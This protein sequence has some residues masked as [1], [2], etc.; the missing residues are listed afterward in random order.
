MHYTRVQIKYKK[1]TRAADSVTHTVHLGSH[2]VH[3]GSH[4]VDLGT[5]AYLVR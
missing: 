1:G 2:R 4:T 5:N 3:S